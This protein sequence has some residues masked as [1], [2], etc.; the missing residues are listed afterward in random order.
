MIAFCSVPLFGLVCSSDTHCEFSR[1]LENTRSSWSQFWDIFLKVWK[2]WW[3][4]A[5]SRLLVQ[6]CGLVKTKS[7]SSKT[8]D[9]QI[10]RGYHFTK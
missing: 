10:Y 1:T 9:F 6:A 8:P 4:K 2:K 5:L 7:I 3:L